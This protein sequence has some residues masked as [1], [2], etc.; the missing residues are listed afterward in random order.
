ML[1]EEA[2]AVCS[3]IHAKHTNALCGRNVELFNVRTRWCMRQP[4]G[5]KV[6]LANIIFGFQNTQK[7][8]SRFVL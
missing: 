3:D 4:L 7:F 8:I 1:C 5:L 2:I 6:H